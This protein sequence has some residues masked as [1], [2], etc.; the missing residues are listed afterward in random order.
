M[1]TVM[2]SAYRV[3]GR[4]GFGEHAVLLRGDD[5]LTASA[6][7]S[8]EGYT[9][10]RFVTP[11]WCATLRSGI[12]Q[13]VVRCLNRLGVPVDPREPLERYHRCVEGRAS[14]HEAV[15]RRMNKL[16]FRC[17]PIH[18]SLVTAR[19]SD[20]C[21]VVLSLANPHYGPFARW[22]SVFGVRIVRPSS[23]DHNPLHRD[24]WLN[25]LRNGVNLYVPI[26]GSDERSSLCLVP[27]SH[28]WSEAEIERT[29]SGALVNGRRYTVPAVTGATRP[30]DVIRPNPGANDVL[31]FSPYLIHG[32]AANLN[33][34][35]TR[36]SLELRLWRRR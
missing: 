26:A 1:T 15:V 22:A 2:E 35:T 4:R 9:V 25:R 7:W 8:A 23:S 24:A 17:L 36:V 33:P 29:K 19:I 6:P 3:E 27:G 12:R 16:P 10:E 32:G 5:D 34:D 21:G 18:P 14:V 28:Q 11:E 30:I 20:I 13:L 31:V